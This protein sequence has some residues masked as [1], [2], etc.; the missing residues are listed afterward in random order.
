MK[1]AH[2]R[3]LVNNTK[4]VR[5]K[6]VNYVMKQLIESKKEIYKRQD[7]FTERKVL[8][9]IKKKNITKITKN[10]LFLYNERY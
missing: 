8:Q 3:N 9:K 6:K 2:K 7:D 1:D 10:I 4:Y 5:T